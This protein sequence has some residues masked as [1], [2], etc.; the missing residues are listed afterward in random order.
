MFFNFFKDMGCTETGA[1]WWDAIAHPPRNEIKTSDCALQQLFSFPLGKTIL[2]LFS[3]ENSTGIL[4]HFNLMHLG[5]CNLDAQ[6]K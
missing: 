4:T 5:I 2:K 1:G 6:R 3:V